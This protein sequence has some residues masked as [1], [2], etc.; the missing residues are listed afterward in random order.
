MT[1]LFSPWTALAGGVLVGLSAS[2]YLLVHGRVAGISGLLG[3]LVTG[4]RPGLDLRASFLLGLVL[5]GL[6][7]ALVAPQS[8]SP[9]PAPLPLLALAGL[10]V[11]AGTRTARGCTSGH[12]VCGISRGSLASIGATITFVATGVLTATL[13]GAWV[14][15]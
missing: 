12:G 11:G 2:I 3:G 7:A 15:R 6:V 8:F 4:R 1:E 10:L 5:A 9:S 14:Q 13:Y